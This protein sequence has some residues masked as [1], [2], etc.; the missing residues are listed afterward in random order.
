MRKTIV[1]LG[2]MGL[3]AVFMLACCSSGPATKVGT[4]G[5]AT[6]PAK[7]MTF[8]VGDQIKLGDRILT[9]AA[10]TRNVADPNGYITP[11][12][13]KEWITIA[14]SIENKG[15]DA[16]TF[17]EF[18]FMIQDSAGKRVNTAYIPGVQNE[19]HSGKVASDGKADGI[20]PFQVPAGDAGLKLV[21]KPF[22]ES[23]IV[24]ALQ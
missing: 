13:G 19:L 22:W 24:I 12:A 15:K 7:P 14:V 1:A 10:P 5:T 2:C 8:K 3:L 21:F 6:T 16:I 18:D 9:V 4:T 11:E 17:N 20:L 23:E